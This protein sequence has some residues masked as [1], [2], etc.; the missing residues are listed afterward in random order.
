[1][2]PEPQPGLLA[3]LLAAQRAGVIDPLAAGAG[4]THKCLVPIAGKP[5]IVHVV[6]ALQATPGLSRLRII[7]EPDAVELI[8]PLLPQGSVPVEFIASA[9]NIADSV[10]AG[11]HGLDQPT[12]VTTADNVLLTPGAVASVQSALRGGADIVFAMANRASV[13]AA[14]PEGQRRFY[15]FSDDEYSNC[16]LFGVAGARAFRGAEMFRG[17]GQFAKKP[18]RLI[19]AI[20]VLNLVQFRLGWLSLAGAMNRLSQRLRLRAEAVVLKD[21]AH[22]IDVDNERTFRVAALLLERRRAARQGDATLR[23]VPPAGSF[24]SAGVASSTAAVAHG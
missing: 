9:A 14:H 4:V 6:E 1:L 2:P 19:A 11:A 13:L 20:G 22:A 15:R 16:N 18:L 23:P 24:A 7:V 5:L 3:I 10:Y 21:G 12:I 17:G 8:R